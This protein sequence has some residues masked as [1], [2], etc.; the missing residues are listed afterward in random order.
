MLEEAIKFTSKTSSNLLP[1]TLTPAPIFQRRITQQIANMEQPDQQALSRMLGGTAAYSSNFNKKMNQ[2]LSRRPDLTPP[3]TFPILPPPNGLPLRI[4]SLSPTIDQLD[5]AFNTTE[6]PIYGPQSMG[7]ASNAYNAAEDETVTKAALDDLTKHVADR[8]PYVQLA[9]KRLQAAAGL[10]NEEIFD[11]PTSPKLCGCP[12]F[13]GMYTI[14]ESGDPDAGR[15]AKMSARNGGRRD[16]GLG[17]GLGPKALGMDMVDKETGQRLREFLLQ[18]CK[19]NGFKKRECRSISFHD[20]TPDPISN[21][22]KN[23]LWGH[24]GADGTGER[25]DVYEVDL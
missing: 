24:Y 7:G 14:P 20:F 5:V 21:K 16:S 3:T 6:H 10:R 17:L 8:T 22:F 19:E 18:K 11:L 2:M 15:G 13:R 12:S 25:V 1:S 23:I 9:S 4:P